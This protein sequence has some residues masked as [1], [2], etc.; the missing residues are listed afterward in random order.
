MQKYDKIF[1]KVSETRIGISQKELNQTRN[2]FVVTSRSV[3]Q[4]RATGRR[5]VYLRLD[6]IFDNRAKINGRWIKLYKKIGVYKLVKIKK[7]SVL[8]KSSNNTREIFIRKNNGSQ[9]KFSSK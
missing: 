2:P 9:I 3:E 6:A 4:R 1:D 5:R 7:S 8:L